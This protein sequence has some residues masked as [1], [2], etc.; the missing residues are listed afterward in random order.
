MVMLRRSVGGFRRGAV[1]TVVGDTG[2]HIVVVEF[3]R[4]D[5]TEDETI[6]VHKRDLRRCVWVNDRNW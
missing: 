4:E 6:E 2:G 3:D 5:G 1:G